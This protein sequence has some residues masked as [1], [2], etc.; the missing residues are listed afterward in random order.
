MTNKLISPKTGISQI[1]KILWFLTYR[2]GQSHGMWE[3]ERNMCSTS[4]SGD[5]SIA[6][7][8][9]LKLDGNQP[10][11]CA[12]GS[13]CLDLTN[14]LRIVIEQCVAY[15]PPFHLLFKDFQEK[16]LN[17]MI[18]W[19]CWREVY[20]TTSI[21]QSNLWGQHTLSLWPS[22]FLDA[23]SLISLTQTNS[24]RSSNQKNLFSEV[25]KSVYATPVF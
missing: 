7:K 24:E 5:S 10:D 23:F 15:W 17:R 22:T 21:F 11:L 2:E 16:S 20:P 12:E 1:L 18:P 6:D 8:E 14:T 9:D 3:L 13:S 25:T 19:W 4:H